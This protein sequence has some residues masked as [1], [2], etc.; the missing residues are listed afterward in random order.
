M[1]IQYSLCSYK[2]HY[3]ITEL[4]RALSLVDRCVYIRVCKHS[5][6]ALELARIFENY[7]IKAIAH[8]FL[9]YIASSKHSG[10]GGRGGWEILESYVN[11][12]RRS[13]SNSPNSPRV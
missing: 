3:K 10:Q 6:D 11:P 2:L 9:V 1:N 4:L 7:F 12:R 8:F 13:V 5:C